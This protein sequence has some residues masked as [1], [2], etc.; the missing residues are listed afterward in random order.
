MADSST[1][2]R[3]AL[4]AGA[5]AVAS[6][7]WLALFGALDASTGLACAASA[8]YLGL[9]FHASR[10]APFFAR[11]R[12]RAWVLTLAVA[13][14]LGPYGVWRAARMALDGSLWD[15][16]AHF[17]VDPSSVRAAVLFVSFLV[18]DTLYGT[19][20]YL[21]Q[22][23]L[24]AGWVHH[25]AYLVFYGC[26]LRWE[27]TVGLAVAFPLELTTVVLA[28]GHLWPPLR[29]D[30]LFGGS[31]LLLRLGYHAYMLRFYYAIPA[32][33]LRVW[34]FMAAVLGLHVHWFAKWCRSQA[35]RARRAPKRAAD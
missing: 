9:A 16:S 11:A 20:E 7:A 1:I 6:A 26:C 5:S 13:A 29:S 30:W 4:L 3:D 12:A 22:F 19:A 31:F 27:L 18:A 32:P 17:S 23:E 24:V 34:P 14:P 25:A 35:K 15:P 2:A 21:Q 8:A 28:V 33:A 10:R